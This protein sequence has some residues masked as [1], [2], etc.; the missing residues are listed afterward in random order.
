MTSAQLRERLGF[1]RSEWAR[2][3]N[4]HERTVARWEAGDV[5]PGGTT[6]AAMRGIADAIDHTQDPAVIRRRLELGGVQGAVFSGLLRK[7]PI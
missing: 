1:S 7:L 6:S 2:A 5:D 3:L 4:V